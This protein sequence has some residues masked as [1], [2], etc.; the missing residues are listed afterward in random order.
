MA[1]RGVAALGGARS[2]LR[3]RMLGWAAGTGAWIAPFD[4]ADELSREAILLAGEFDDDRLLG[5]VLVNDALF[6]VAYYQVGQAAESARKGAALL[7]SGGDRW[8]MTLARSCEVFTLVEL[9]RF[10]GLEALEAEVAEAADRL[11]QYPALFTLQWVAATRQLAVAP[12]LD[13]FE[14][15][16]RLALEMFAGLG[17]ESCLLP[18]L[19]L[20]KFMRGDWDAALDLMAEGARH[21]LPN[22]LHGMA[23]GPLFQILAYRGERTAALAVLEAERATLPRPGMPNGYG[24]WQFLCYVVEGLYVLG[25]RDACAA[26]YPLVVEFLTTGV[27]LT[28]FQGRLVERVAGMAAAAGRH[29]D[30]AESHFQTAIRQ[31]QGIPHRLEAAETARFHARMLLDRSAGEDR[32]RAADLLDDALGRYH[33]IGMARHVRM[34]SDLRDEVLAKPQ[35]DPPS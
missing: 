6:R 1:R 5:G 9:G 17:F 20:G 10:D 2:P 18:R 27:V 26:L 30:L 4:M 29:W 21:E 8:A 3:A 33:S 15:S 28:V 25:E 31:A 16:A 35:P 19:G 13:R 22:R 34:A 14:A 32:A 23:V 24:S 7:R 12:D 11:G